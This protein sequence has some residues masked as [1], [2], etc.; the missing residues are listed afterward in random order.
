MDKSPSLDIR[1]IFGSRLGYVSRQWRRAVDERLLLFGLTEATW[2]PLLYVARS[3]M[4]MRQKDLAELIG[5]ESS[6]L[7]RLIDALDHAELIERRTDGDRRARTLCL[8]PRGLALVEQ[9]EVVSAAIR[10]QILAGITDE[11]LTITLSVIDRICV[12]LTQARAP[13]QADVQ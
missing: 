1:Q 3:R 7:V 8:T 2:L 10:Q 4:P 13:E 12:A 5:I 9:V 11:E 6:T